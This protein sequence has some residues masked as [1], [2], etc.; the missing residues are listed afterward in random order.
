MYRELRF[1]GNV[2]RYVENATKNCKNADLEAVFRS[3]TFRNEFVAALLLGKVVRF[4]VNG[5]ILKDFSR[6]P[7]MLHF[8]S[9][10]EGIGTIIVKVW[11]N[12]L[13]RTHPVKVRCI[14]RN[15]PQILG[16]MGSP[17]ITFF[18]TVFER[19][20]ERSLVGNCF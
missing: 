15:Y 8:C 11:A 17:Q 20:S 9:I 2:A 10:T 6:G 4:A 14:S 19:F 16:K 18:Q 12:G 7:E 3:K 13:L 1:L 5:Q